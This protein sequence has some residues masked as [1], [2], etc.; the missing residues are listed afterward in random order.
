MHFVLNATEMEALFRQD[1]SKRK[2]GGYQSLL[3]GLQDNCDRTTGSITVM[4][5]QRARI[6]KYAFQYGNGGWED[7]L[8]TTFARHLG[9]LLDKEPS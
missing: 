6:R 9:P 8:T 4:V 3:V 1:A 7:R 2:D 5:T